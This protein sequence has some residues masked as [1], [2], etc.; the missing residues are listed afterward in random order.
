[1]NNVDTQRVTDH[2]APTSGTAGRARWYMAGLLGVGMFVNY[3]DRV[4]LS[5]ATPAIM[6]DFDISAA[7]MGVVSSAFLWT[8]A[9]LQMPIGS[10]IDRIGVPWVNRVGTFLW[11]VASFLSAAAGGLGL[12]IVARLLLGVGE[13][14]TVPAGWKAIGQ[15]FPKHERGTAT[16]I[17]DGCAKIS[18]VVGIPV[19]AFLVSTFS[20][21]AAFLFTGALSL[22]FFVAWWLLYRSPTVAVAEGRMS[23]DEL[24]YLRRGGAEDENTVTAGSLR[25]VGYLLRRRKTW[26]LA[27]GYASYTYAYYVL[28]T[29][30]PGYLEHQFGVNLLKGGFYTMIPWLVAV[31]AQFVVA[32]VLMDRWVARTGQ[33]TKVRRIVLVVS[34]LASLAVTGAAYSQSIAVAIVFLSVGAAGLAVSVPAGASIVSLIAPEGYTGTLGGVVNFIA[35]LIG[36][37]APIV[38]GAVVDRTGSFA[39]AFIVTGAVLIA[40]IFCYTVVLGKMDRM[41]APA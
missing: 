27:L 19:M 33:V 6:A 28:L 40:G 21:H 36:I 37:A 16:A 11:A 34:M 5:V 12:L 15:W 23:A 30:L 14:P 3:I 20:W 29:W 17:F 18:N 4:N 1:M 38:T 10:I 26:G 35:N 25:G 24:D 8:Y 41:P 22:L 13:A 32:G 2:G 7:Q 9:M 31:I 39:G